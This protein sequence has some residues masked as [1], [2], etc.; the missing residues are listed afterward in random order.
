MASLRILFPTL[1]PW[2]KQKVSDETQNDAQGEE[3]LQF[4]FWETLEAA[5]YLK[6]RLI[7]PSSILLSGHVVL[8]L[9][10]HL[11]HHLGYVLRL[12]LLL[13]RVLELLMG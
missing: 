8:A 5:I 1:R 12:L 3:Q 10:L 4:N 6:N 9:I 13:L 11:E 2:E 7:M